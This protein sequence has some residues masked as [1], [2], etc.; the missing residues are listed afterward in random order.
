M[1]V[2][3]I[4][5]KRMK[6]VSLQE[7]MNRMVT[8]FETIKTEGADSYQKDPWTEIKAYIGLD[9]VLGDLH[10]Q[11][12]D[13][14][15][16]HKKLLTENGKSDAMT[17]I[18]L[19]VRASTV[20]AIETRV[21]ELRK[22]EAL[23]SVVAYRMRRAEIDREQ[24]LSAETKEYWLQIRGYNEAQMRTKARKKREEGTSNFLAAIVFLNLVQQMLTAARHNRSIASIVDAARHPEYGQ[25]SEAAA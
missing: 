2:V 11:Y 7:I 5:R 13:A 14:R 6:K 20:S 21:I 12:L 24:E 17:E 15:A 19:D 4:Q 23:R 3:G 10:K 1:C 16:Q 18:A 25:R 9:P 22:D 8:R